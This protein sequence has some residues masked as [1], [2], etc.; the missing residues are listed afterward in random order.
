METL[1]EIGKKIAKLV[2]VKSIISLMVTIVFCY[3]AC[4]EVIPTDKFFD[5]YIMI[6]AFYFGT[7]YQKS[8]NEKEE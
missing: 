1:K 7:Q 2:D 8:K 6:I 3:L 4:K 5:I